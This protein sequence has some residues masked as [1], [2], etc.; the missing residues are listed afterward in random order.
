MILRIPSQ[1][2][3]G[4]TVYGL[5]ADLIGLSV[6]KNDIRYVFNHDRKDTDDKR[7][8]VPERFTDVFDNLETHINYL[9]TRVPI[10]IV[11]NKH[12]PHFDSTCEHQV[13]ETFVVFPCDLSFNYGSLTVWCT[14]FRPWL[15]STSMS[16]FDVPGLEFLQLRG[17]TCARRHG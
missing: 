8:H 7:L 15:G 13:Y 5:R 9:P 16:T 2:K 17:N 3:N 10:T 11:W 4:S 6:P 1:S 12:L 14:S